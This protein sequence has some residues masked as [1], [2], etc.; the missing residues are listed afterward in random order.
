VSQTCSSYPK[1]SGSDKV[2]Q[3]LLWPN[4]ESGEARVRLGKEILFLNKANGVNGVVS[5]LLGL[6]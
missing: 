3:R 6:A 2:T 4:Y 5:G 1:L